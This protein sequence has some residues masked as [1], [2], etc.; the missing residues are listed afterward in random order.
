M[1]DPKSSER[2]VSIHDTAHALGLAEITVRR[3]IRRGEIH[4]LR[5]GR[6]LRVPVAEIERLLA[7]SPASNPAPAR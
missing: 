4:A 1:T 5:V 7:P 3:A 6:V 2:A